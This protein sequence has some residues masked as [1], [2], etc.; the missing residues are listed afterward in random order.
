MSVHAA[1]QHVALHVG[2]ERASYTL[3]ATVG[4]PRHSTITE[5][6]LLT[7]ATFLH[8]SAERG[9]IV[10]RDG[11][12]ALRHPGG[13]ETR[14]TLFLAAPLAR[15]AVDGI[16]CAAIPVLRAPSTLMCRFHDMLAH[17]LDIAT[18]PP[19]VRDTRA[20]EVC[21]A[22]AP[23]DT[24][25]LEWAPRAAPRTLQTPAVSSHL[26]ATFTR[27]SPLCDIRWDIDVTDVRRCAV[28]DAY[29]LPVRATGTWDTF[30]VIGTADVHAARGAQPA[31][32]TL[33]ATPAACGALLQQHAPFAFSI[34]GR[35][36]VDP[37]DPAL[38]RIVLPGMRTHT[39]TAA[40]STHG[41]LHAA[42]HS[43]PPST[44]TE[45]IG[46]TQRC[47]AR[48]AD[49]HFYVHLREAAAPPSA[50]LAAASVHHQVW[51]RAGNH[52]VHHVRIDAFPA[53]ADEVAVHC[54]GGDALA[55]VR[56]CVNGAD[57]DAYTTDGALALRM[58]PGAAALVGLVFTTAWDGAADLH[59]HRLGIRAQVYTLE[60]HGTAERAARVCGAP[61]HTV[62][63]T[64]ERPTAYPARLERKQRT[65]PPLV[66]PL[67][68]TVLLGAAFAGLARL[69]YLATRMLARIDALAM[70]LDIDFHDGQWSAL[71]V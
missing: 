48:G 22:F 25:V 28:A 6:P 52:L 15:R 11:T 19:V 63:S 1:Q 4:V 35:V 68:Y 49:V 3:T 16:A 21:G 59:I 50:V 65:S 67:V 37:R 34:I 36:R 55:D 26:A 8:G 45:H 64:D 56:A 58:P 40:V 10:C 70:A 61:Q 42:L 9:S 18:R 71:H 12:V 44:A 29:T 20:P 2:T 66:S 51:P 60:M 57:A 41:G 54:A 39:A 32:A 7:G 5:V 53:A 62:F 24:F 13:G 33:T 47:T 14:I 27:G 46:H 69:F 31:S 23:T 43:L 30:D 17:A 38:P